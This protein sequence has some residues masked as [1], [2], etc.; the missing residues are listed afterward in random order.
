MA[1]KWTS[2]GLSDLARLNDFLAP[3]NP[4]AAARVVQAL[5]TA[6][7][8]LRAN[9]RIG[10]RLEE[11][12]PREVRRILIGNYEMRYEIRGGII[13]ILRIWHTREER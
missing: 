5:T 10:E 3:V 11:F 9:P 8:G 6:P 4:A 12:D 13:Y 2:K 7:A 1:L